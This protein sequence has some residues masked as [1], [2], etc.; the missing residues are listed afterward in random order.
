MRLIRLPALR[1]EGAILT[2]DRILKA[3]KRGTSVVLPQSKGLFAMPEN[4]FTFLFL[5]SRI[6][7]QGGQSKPDR[8]QSVHR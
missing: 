8:P 6:A 1:E 2:K 3:D 7:K 4:V 5:N